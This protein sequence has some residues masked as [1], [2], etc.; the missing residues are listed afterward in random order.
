MAS[1]VV[2]AQNV[3]AQNEIRVELP[4]ENRLSWLTRPYQ[5]RSVTPIRLTNSSRLESL[6]RAGILYLTAQDVVALAIEN[7]IDVEVQRYGPL[8]AQE[9]LKRAKAGGALRSVGAGV[10]AGPQSVSLQGV[11]LNASGDAGGGGGVGSGGGITTQLGPS[12]QSLDPT[13]TG[14]ANFGHTTSPQSNTVISGTTS[15]VTNVR[16]FQAS[17]SKNWEWGMN[18]QLSYSANHI[19]VNSQFFTLNP[20]TTG[21]IDLQ[22]TQSLLQGFGS[23]VNTR[24]IRVQKNNL[25]ISD[26]Q[27]KQQLITTTSAVLSCM[28]K[29]SGLVKTCAASQAFRIQ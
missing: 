1:A 11:S 14:L 24:N 3:T 12:I 15:L 7:N 16:T 27:F 4:Q 20:Y 6:T 10:S 26:L 2:T 22:V 28:T 18:S 25:K 29:L 13:V 17:I 21:S 19:S 5:A 23:A 9:V 8:L